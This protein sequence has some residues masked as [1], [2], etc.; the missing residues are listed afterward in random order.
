VTVIVADDPLSM[1]ARVRVT[2]IVDGKPEQTFDRPASERTTIEL[3]LG[4][5]L[6]VRVAAVDEHGN[7]LAELG[8]REVPIVILGKG[9]P[10]PPPRPIVAAPPR[11]DRAPAP[12][13][14]RAPRPLYLKWWLWGGA[15]V[16]FGGAA[17]YFGI[18]A[19]V[20]RRDLEQLNR[21]S[22]NHNF[23]EAKALESRARR[24]LLF[25]NIGYGAAAAFAVTGAILYLTEPRTSRGRG[26]QRVG[27]APIAGGGAIVFG[28]KF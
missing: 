11:P 16:A 17:T 2:V 6:D 14:P 13:R 7:R 27:V 3:P 20:A 18:D 12:E 22:V 10:E 24:G 9:L 15:A 5:R 4:R 25:A 8:S 21:D 26:E 19:L 1:I 23:D 28:G